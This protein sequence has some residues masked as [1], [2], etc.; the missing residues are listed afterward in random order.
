MGKRDYYETL[1]VPRD[2]TQNDIKKAYRKKAME[3]HPDRNPGDKVAEEKFKEVAEAYETLSAPLKRQQYDRYGHAGAAGPT[4]GFGFDFGGSHDPFEI[5]REV[6]GG[7]FGDFFGGSTSGRTRTR[8]QVGSDLQIRLYLSLEEI[9]TGVTKQINIKKLVACDTCNGSG[10]SSGSGWK[11]CPVCQGAGQ[12]RHTQGFFSVSRTCHQCGGRGQ[13]IEQ[14]CR[15]CGGEGRVKGSKTIQVKIPPGVASGQYLTVRGEGNIGPYNGP[16]GDVIVLIEEKKHDLFERHG[17]DVL[18]DLP[19][20]FS[21]LALGDE[22]EIPTLNG[23]VKIKIAPG[24]HSG[25]IFRLRGKGITHLDGPG[26]G[27]QLVRVQAWTPTKLTE[28]EKKLFRE[29]AKSEALKPPKNDKS[30]FRKVKEAMF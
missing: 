15:T 23:R 28:A 22:V 26:T 2:A 8:A 11:T 3:F 6:F 7:G 21:Q 1:G 10:A 24:T 12:I 9:A 14:P 13:V 20:S 29:L 19:L 30:F 25:K 16:A 4:G 5:F 27:D 17:D 18:Y